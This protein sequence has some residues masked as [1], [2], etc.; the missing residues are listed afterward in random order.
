MKRAAIEAIQTLVRKRPRSQSVSTLAE[1]V[2]LEAAPEAA[3]TAES[4]LPSPTFRP[5]ELPQTLSEQQAQASRP[6]TTIS[7]SGIIEEPSQQPTTESLFETLRTQ[8]FEML[9][10]SMV[11]SLTLAF[12]AIANQYR[13][14]SPILPKG[15]SLVLVLLSISTLKL[16]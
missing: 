4:K 14:H 15:L 16:I 6:T 13:D 3:T 2:K 8:Y 11:R 12:V 5:E 9:Y 10:K 1:S 7:T